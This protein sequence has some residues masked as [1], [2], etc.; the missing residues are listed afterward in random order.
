MAGRPPAPQPGKTKAKGKAPATRPQPK[1]VGSIFGLADVKHP[2]QGVTATEPTQPRARR[3][4]PLVPGTSMT[5]NLTEQV[6]LARARRQR[7]AQGGLLSALQSAKENAAATVV[8]SQPRFATPPPATTTAPPRRVARETAAA[9]APTTSLAGRFGA[10]PTPKTTGGS[11][12]GDILGRLNEPLIGKGAASAIG[13][14]VLAPAAKVGQYAVGTGA[15]SVLAALGVGSTDI[16][17]KSAL[18][19]SS[20]VLPDEPLARIARAGLSAPDISIP[21]AS[22]NFEGTAYAGGPPNARIPFKDLMGQT[23]WSLKPDYKAKLIKIARDVQGWNPSDLEGLSATDQIYRAYNKPPGLFSRI[24]KGVASDVVLGGSMTVG[25]AGLLSEAAQGRGAQALNDYRHALASV[26]P[27]LAAHPV[28]DVLLTHPLFAAT[29]L[30]GGLKSLGAV[31]HLRPGVPGERSFNL[32]ST[33]EPVNLGPRSKNLVT[34]AGQELGDLSARLPLVGGPISRVK[35]EHKI[36]DQAVQDAKDRTNPEHI[37]VQVPQRNAALALPKERRQQLIAHAG[38]GG[39]PGLED[40]AAHFERLAAQTGDARAAN[41]A[42][43]LHKTLADTTTLSPKDQA[44]LDAYHATQT[45]TSNVFKGLGLHGDVAQRYRQYELPIEHAAS[46]GDALAKAT[47]DARNAFEDARNS[48][49]DGPSPALRAKIT[50]V[51]RDVRRH[52]GKAVPTHEEW[53]AKGKDLAKR[54]PTLRQGASEAAKGKYET[55]LR[56]WR[57]EKARHARMGGRISAHTTE[58]R[59]QGKRLEGLNAKQAAA[60]P[61]D[62]LIR[63]AHD[64]YQAL[65]DQFIERHLAQPGATPAAYTNYVKPKSEFP[66]PSRLSG[67]QR[68]TPKM[69]REYRSSG[70]TARS[71]NFQLDWRASLQANAEAQ[72]VR[73]H[74]GVYNEIINHPMVHHTVGDGEQGVPRGYTFTPLENL[75]SVEKTAPAWDEQ[76]IALHDNTRERGLRQ[77]FAN[78]V[79]SNTKGQGEIIPRGVEGYLVP[80]GMHDRIVAWATPRKMT[81]YD[82]ANAA[83]QRA[84]IG[85]YP[86]T[87]LGNAPGSLPLALSSGALPGSGAYSLA[88]RSR[89]S[90]EPGIAPSTLSGLGVGGRTAAAGGNWLDRMLGKGREFSM[91]GEDFTSRAAYFGQAK[92]YVEGSL[93]LVRKMFP[94][95]EKVLPERYKGIAQKLNKDYETV[96]RALAKGEFE[97]NAPLPPEIKAARDRMIRH[98]QSFAGAAHKP[99]GELGRHIGQVILFHSWLGHILKLTLITLPLKHPRRAMLLNALSVYGNQYRQEHGAYP[100]WMAQFLP[101]LK[102]SQSIGGGRSAPGVFSLGLGQLTPMSSA[103]T[104]AQAGTQ[105]DTGSP[106]ALAAGV[107]SPLLQPFLKA[108]IAAHDNSKLRPGEPG[109]V[110]PLSVIVEGAK[111][112]IPGYR[113]FQPASGSDLA[114][115]RR[116]YFEYVPNPSGKGYKRYEIPYAMRP[117]GRPLTGPLGDLS[118]VF[119][120]PIEWNPTGGVPLGVEQGNQQTIQAANEIKREL[121]KK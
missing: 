98:A 35:I 41:W 42:T 89:P 87:W 59:Q 45:H 77:S 17:T 58:A 14:D 34:A 55:D 31:G 116:H 104:L 7:L 63:L 84:L 51:T 9:G 60:L 108:L 22:L 120:L 109:R 97:K 24:A 21:K 86:S 23:G 27:G 44:F 15:A 117:G 93:P 29:A 110:D 54:R 83:Y 20:Y 78:A 95:I 61:R 19:R 75:R 115:N 64:R 99:Q 82:R 32:R 112:I 26:T 65:T 105:L 2:F 101:V 92:R 114:G 16:L 62:E 6:S 13:R 40:G 80:K 52:T 28:G 43:F 12:L 3:A 11:P 10:V 96:Y 74:V 70:N 94:A 69:A 48:G 57:N 18:K 73:S 103:G 119:G 107:T 91:H 56:L 118:R 72:R 106:L 25:A 30:H 50:E 37:A 5:P 47:I 39:T 81:R 38:W 33:G 100:S 53:L 102:A 46:G 88:L 121:A 71:G 111:Q 85:I 36:I 76:L 68:F 49:P 4:G 1:Q 90:N 113:K 79:Q 66:H 67:K 8:P